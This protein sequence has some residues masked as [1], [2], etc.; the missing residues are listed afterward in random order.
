MKIFDRLLLA[1]GL[2]IPFWLL[3]GVMLTAQAYPGYSHLQQAMSQLGAVDAP[4]HTLSP[5]INNFPLALLFALFAWGVARRWRQSR[6]AQ[7]SALLI[8]LHA[9]GSLG[10]GWFTC[11][12]GC[13][14]VTPSLSQQLH[15]LSGLLMFLSLTLASVLWIG[16]GQRLA[17]S[18]GLAWWSLLCTVLAVVTV[19]LMARA[20][21]SGQLFGLYQRLNYGVSMLWLAALALVSL[22]PSHHNPLRMAIA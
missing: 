1:S 18:R 7:L 11:D 10:T 15:N 4:T 6:L 5:W 22:R 3:I 16:L 20:A 9:V 12:A 2:L 17:R 13:A 19:L 14:P 8:L 21:E